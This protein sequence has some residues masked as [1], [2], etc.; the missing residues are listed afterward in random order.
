MLPAVD[1]ACLLHRLVVEL[2]GA[3]HTTDAEIASDMRRQRY[4][5]SQGFMVLRF[6]NMDVPAN[7]DGVM[8]SIVCALN[9]L[10][11]EVAPIPNPSPQGGGE[12]LSAR[13][14]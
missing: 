6:N 4:L 3:T 13:G 8:E 7:V 9:S 12:Q 5:E 2:D 11:G 10:E 14:K 1:F